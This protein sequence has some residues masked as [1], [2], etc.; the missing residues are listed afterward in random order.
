[1]QVLQQLHDRFGKRLYQCVLGFIRSLGFGWNIDGLALFIYP[2]PTHESE[3]AE[4]KAS[5]KA[6]EIDG[7]VELVGLGKRRDYLF[8]KF[9]GLKSNWILIF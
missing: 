4:T 3:L 1:M 6:H 2:R 8:Y 5:E 7:T 9:I